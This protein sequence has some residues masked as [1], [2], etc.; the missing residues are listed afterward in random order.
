MITD[1]TTDRRTV[2]LAFAYSSTIRARTLTAEVVYVLVHAENAIGLGEAV[3]LTAVTG[4]TADSIEAAVRG[5]IRNVMLGR[6]IAELERNLAALARALPGNW[7]AKAGVDIALHD[8]HARELGIA[9]PA[10]LGGNTDRVLETSMTVSSGSLEEMSQRA[11]ELV[12]AGFTGVK[13]KVGGD[14]G[15]DVRK[16][17]AVRQAVGPETVIRLDANQGWT[18]REAVSAIRQ[19]EDY[20]CGVELIE[21]PVPAADLAGLRFVRER[22]QTPIVADEA[23]ISPR[24]AMTVIREDAADVISVKVQKNGG[25]A[26]VRQILAVAA[27]VDLPCMIGCSL[28]TAVSITAG[29]AVAAASPGVRFVDLDAPLWLAEHPVIGGCRSSGRLISLTSDPGHGVSLAPATTAERRAV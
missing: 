20:G 2:S 26:G 17:R 28:E 25:I 23:V 6:P 29:A 1:L 22:V 16:V 21:Q 18:R 13:L 5:P 9:L 8:L 19:M 15:T 3:P 11:G 7:S 27:A 14:I 24:D 4:E 10:L 12:T